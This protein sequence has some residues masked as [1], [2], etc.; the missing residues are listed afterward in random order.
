M[1]HEGPIVII[2]DDQD[3][4]DILVDVANELNLP[5]KLQFFGNT[6]E[7][8]A[9]LKNTSDKPLVIISDINL[10]QESGVELKRRIDE[11]YQLREKSIP[12]IF[13]STFI[14]KRIVDIAYKELTIQGF[15]KKSNH[16]KEIRDTF[17]MI[18]DYWSI[19]KHPNS[20]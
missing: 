17:K 2:D 4:Q 1:N 3:D 11:D 18:V 5:N 14:E 16:Y 19:C 8:F 13:F 9:Y 20:I 10:P 15:F 6:H 7:A 12:F